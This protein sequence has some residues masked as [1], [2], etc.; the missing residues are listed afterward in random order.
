[1]WKRKALV[2]VVT[3]ALAF[4]MG[5]S[6]QNKSNELK[7]GKYVMQD[8]EVENKSWVVIKGN[9]QFE[10]NR[11]GSLS[12]SYIP[13]GTYSIE[14]NTL[15]LAVSEKEMYRFV[16]DGEKLVFKSGNIPEDWVKEGAIFKLADKE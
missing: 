3:F 5:C 15:T 6:L 8:T 2:L 9:N 12:L 11:N 10:F 14:D 16:V 4:T 1:M 7:T 13:M